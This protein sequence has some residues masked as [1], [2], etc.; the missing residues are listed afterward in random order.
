MQAEVDSQLTSALYARNPLAQPD[1][2]VDAV[3]GLWMAT[4]TLKPMTALSNNATHTRQCL[5]MKLGEGTFHEDS[6]WTK[7]KKGLRDCDH[8]RRGEPSPYPRAAHSGLLVQ[9]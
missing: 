6:V 3:R 7:R 8:T 2:Y 5:G 1:Q 9:S 4:K